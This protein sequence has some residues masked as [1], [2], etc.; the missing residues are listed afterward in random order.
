MIN[1]TE[2][3]MWRPVIYTANG[4]GV[5]PE[6]GVIASITEH[7]VRVHFRG[8]PNPAACLR[9]NLVWETDWRVQQ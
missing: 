6:V 4:P 2:K 7:F 1:P 3:D 5:E 8:E 9:E